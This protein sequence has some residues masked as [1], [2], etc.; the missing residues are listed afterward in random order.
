[1]NPFQDE[2][3]QIINKARFDHLASL[4]LPLQGKT[5]LE[6]GA[7]VGDQTAFLLK[8]FRPKRIHATD[9]RHENCDAMRKR[10]KGDSRVTV[11]NIDVENGPT[12]D[13]FDVVHCYGLLY[14]L[15]N[16]HVALKWMAD[17]THGML[18]LETCVSGDHDM[19]INLDREA[20]NDPRSSIHGLSCR[21]SREWIWAILS[22]WFKF[23]Y[24][25]RAQPNHSEFITDW[26][27][28]DWKTRTLRAVFVASRQEIQNQRLSTELLLEQ[29]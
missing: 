3:Y 26:R 10:F 25:P 8:Q 22:Q 20:N 24:I 23:I 16:P 4:D 15:G 21:P 18:L 7:G 1:M 6:V 11:E 2:A 9:G 29:V 13:T 12:G 28:P 19:G 27:N 14:H 17:R 5:F